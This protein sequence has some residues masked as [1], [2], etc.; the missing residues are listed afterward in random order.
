MRSF[1]EAHGLVDGNIR[2]LISLVENHI[3]CQAHSAAC[4]L[5]DTFRLKRGELDV[6]PVATER[7]QIWH[8]CPDLYYSVNVSEEAPN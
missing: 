5:S 1:L 2:D 7:N 6:C 3:L 8:S 4:V